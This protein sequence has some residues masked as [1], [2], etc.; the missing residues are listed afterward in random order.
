MSREPTQNAFPLF[1]QMVTLFQMWVV[2]LYFTIKLYWWRF[3][4]IWVL[5]SAVT[6]FVTFRATRKPLVQTTPRL[7]RVPGK[8]PQPQ[9]NHYKEL[10]RVPGK[11]PQPQGNHYKELFPVPLPQTIVLNF[12]PP[13][14]CN[15]CL[16]CPRPSVRS[17]NRLLAA[18]PMHMIPE[19]AVERQIPPGL[20]ASPRAFPT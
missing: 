10:F 5:F 2:P 17:T 9:G 1:L 15:P 14:V 8:T 13:G 19:W 12:A 16:R 7:V 3:L 18:S 4:V 11:T 20:V 6:A